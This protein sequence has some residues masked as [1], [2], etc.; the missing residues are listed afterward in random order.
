MFRAIGQIKNNIVISLSLQLAPVLSLTTLKPSIWKPE[1]LNLH[2]Q[3][4]SNIFFP[5]GPFCFHVS[6]MT[7]RADI[8]RG[9]SL[10]CSVL[11]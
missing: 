11:F 8:L 1:V 9:S 4:T 7:E 2:E 6:S 5:P 10:F 3:R